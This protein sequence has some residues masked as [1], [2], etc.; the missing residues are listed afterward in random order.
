MPEILDKTTKKVPPQLQEILDIFLETYEDKI[1]E[2]AED[3]VEESMMNLLPYLKG[4]KGDSGLE[5]KSA[6][7]PR[8][9]V[10]YFTDLDQDQFATRILSLIPKPENGKDAD[11]VRV[12][13]RVLS[14]IQ[15]PEIDERGIIKK[16]LSSI[17]E[18]KE[19]TPEEVKEKLM[20]LPIAGR[21][22]DWKHIKNAPVS[23][24]GK[25]HLGRGTGSSVT[26]EDITSQCDG[27]T[28]TFTVPAHVRALGVWSTQ[29]PLIYRPTTD[30]TT[31]G[32]TLTL[33]SAVGAP[34]TGQTLIFLYVAQ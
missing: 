7:T 9:G 10:D 19:V 12:V 4:E 33:T 28:K 13:R 11:E 1:K 20:E 18:I 34:D 5:G 24:S 16:V 23:L 22:F 31:S 32:T 30:F 17:P 15:L 25:K 3:K 8:R 21:W 26:M 2:I 29:F 27:V 6:Q 14:K